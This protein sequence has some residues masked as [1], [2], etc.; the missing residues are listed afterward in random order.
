MKIYRMHRFARLAG[1]YTGAML[2]GGRWNRIGTPM[3]Y[4]AEHLFLACVEVL[5]HLDKSQMPTNYVWSMAEILKE[6]ML[7]EFERLSDV[8]SC[9]QAGE[10]WIQA[11]ESLT[12][13]V[14]SVVIPE[15]F[16]VLLNPNHPS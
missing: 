12:V 9:Q 5:V 3:L 1:D 15:E 8:V 11:G 4:S 6:P 10:S 13:R 2:A 16:N 14:P 7:L